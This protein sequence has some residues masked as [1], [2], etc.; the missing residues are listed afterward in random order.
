MNRY[1]LWKYC[2]IAVITALGI[3]YALPNLY[4]EEPAVQVSAHSGSI[5]SAETLSKIEA[6]L[7]A[8]HLDSK[9]M[10]SESNKN[11]SEVDEQEEKVED[12]DELFLLVLII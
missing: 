3:L 10:S 7:V 12:L 11:A 8:A 5:I 6:E 9:S 1:P 2:I 4:G